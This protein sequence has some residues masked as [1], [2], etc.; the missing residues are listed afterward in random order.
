MK[1]QMLLIVITL[2]TGAAATAQTSPKESIQSKMPEYLTAYLQLKD[3]LFGDNAAKAKTAA[4]NL[5]AKITS[6]GIDDQK[7]VGSI[8]TALMTIASTNDIE[9]QRIAFAKVSQHIIT[10]LKNN[11]VSGVTLYSDFCPMAR[12]GKGAYWVSTDK[13]I[14][15][16]PYMGAKMPH[17]GTMDEKLSK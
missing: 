15:N 8:N 3:A 17:C 2:L 10:L 7:K 12:D 14:N 5:K 11:P 6:A 4:T 1:T 13:E 9:E 16:N